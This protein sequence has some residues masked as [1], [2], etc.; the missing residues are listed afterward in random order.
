M[1]SLIRRTW[2]RSHHQMFRAFGFERRSRK[3]RLPRLVLLQP[4]PPGAQPKERC[5]QESLSRQREWPAATRR[6]RS[7]DQGQNSLPNRR[8][9]RQS[10]CRRSSASVSSCHLS[11]A[12]SLALEF[13]AAWRRSCSKTL[14]PPRCLFGSL[15]KSFE[16]PHRAVYLGVPIEIRKCT[17][18]S[19][20]SSKSKPKGLN[21]PAAA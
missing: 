15:R 20:L 2:K 18:K 12:K 11:P 16:S 19:F 5:K 17:R 9:R 8:T 1:K 10:S 4:G 14:S 7:W 6:G 3:P 21:S 13:P